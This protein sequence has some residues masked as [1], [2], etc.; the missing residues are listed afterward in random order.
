MRSMA[1]LGGVA[2]AWAA[3]ST[4]DLVTELPDA[5]ALLSRHYSGFLDLSETKHHHYYLVESHN[6]PASDPLILW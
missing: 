4:L 2:C 6:D 1:V 3:S 5:P